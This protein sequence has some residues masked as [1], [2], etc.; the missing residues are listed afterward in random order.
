MI[1]LA[2]LA[3]LLG[4]CAASTKPTVVQLPALPAD[5]RVCFVGLAAIPDRDLTVA[6][7]ERLWK[8]DRRRS[9]AMRRCGLR[10]IVWYDKLRE[11]WR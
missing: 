7:V 10:V 4:A 3:T 1:V 5:I 11:T 8:D 9:A 6:D 2:C